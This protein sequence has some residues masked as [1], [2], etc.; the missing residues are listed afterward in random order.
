MPTTS[1]GT[2]HDR[3]APSTTTC[4]AGIANGS[5]P[6]RPRSPTVAAPITMPAPASVTGGTASGLAATAQYE[7][8]PMA[9]IEANSRPTGSRWTFPATSSTSTSPPAASAAPASTAP[10]GR[11]RVRTQASASS[12]R[13]AVY[14]TSRATAIGSLSTA[15]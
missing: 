8:L 6:V 10:D 13:G 9:A 11:R 14:S 5:S 7:A 12:S 15:R 4:T 2:S 1:T 3:C